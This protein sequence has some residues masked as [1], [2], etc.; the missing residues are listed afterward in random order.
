MSITDKG[1]EALLV[2]DGSGNPQMLKWTV[3]CAYPRYHGLCKRL[4]LN[5]ELGDFIVCNIYDWRLTD[6][7]TR[8]P[9]NY[10]MSEEEAA[11]IG[12]PQS[13][14]IGTRCKMNT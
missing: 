6:Q 10:R 2:Y 12:R 5:F 1:V 14:R 11:Q 8:N 13:N 9:L 3:L 4:Q 7:W